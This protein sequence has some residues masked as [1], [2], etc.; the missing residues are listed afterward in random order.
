MEE[1]TPSITP[2]GTYQ[3]SIEGTVTNAP[4]KVPTIGKKPI[5]S[6]TANAVQTFETNEAMN[7]PNANRFVVNPL[8]RNTFTMKND[9]APIAAMLKRF[10][11]KVVM[12]PSP[13]AKA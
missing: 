3:T 13:R 8:E 9:N 6:P 1:T 11:P 5:S 10:A 7:M 4:P 12:P 2:V